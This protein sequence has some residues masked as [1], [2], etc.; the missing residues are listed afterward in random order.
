MRS[1]LW[2]LEDCIAPVQ[3]SY[4]HMRTMD[5]T[6]TNSASSWKRKVYQLRVL[7]NFLYVKQIF[8]F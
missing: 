8:S 4:R 7:S 2:D 6:H 3:E 1:L 5:D